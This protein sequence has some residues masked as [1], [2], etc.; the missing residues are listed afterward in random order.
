MLRN[1][2][3]FTWMFVFM[4]SYLVCIVA[5]SKVLQE[6]QNTPI[7][8]H[9]HTSKF[10]HTHTHTHPSHRKH[11]SIFICPCFKKWKWA[12][13]PGQIPPKPTCG[14]FFFFSDVLGWFFRLDMGGT[15]H[16]SRYS[17]APEAFLQHRGQTWSAA[18]WDTMEVFQHTY[19]YM[20]CQRRAATGRA[21]LA[22]TPRATHHLC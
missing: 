16:P 13:S 14:C 11:T 18:M 7:C 1:S 6:H 4:G 8:T 22:F 17:S 21:Q 20:I 2:Y 15:S 12:G 19:K 3:S 9:L 10:S 5:W